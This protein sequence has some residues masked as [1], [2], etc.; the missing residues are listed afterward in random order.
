MKQAVPPLELLADAPFTFRS[1]V[2]S[3]NRKVRKAKFT[4]VNNT[5]P[6]AAVCQVRFNGKTFEVKHPLSFEL[7]VPSAYGT[8]PVK[9]TAKDAA[10]KDL[11]SVSLPFRVNPPSKRE[12]AF[13][14]DRVMLIDGKP[15][16]PLG[17]WSVKGPKSNAEKAKIIAEC[18]FNI[19]KASNP[20]QMDDFAEHGMMVLM[21]VMEKL[22]NFKDEAHF[23]RW[24]KKYRAAMKK[25]REHPSLIGYFISDEPAWRGFPCE[26]L[27][28]AY[29]YIRKID[30][31]RPIMLNEAPRGEIRAN[32]L[33]A[34]AADIYG[35]DIYPVP[36]PNP[37]SGLN[38]KNMTSVGKYT[39]VCRQV[40]YDRKP[41]WMTLQAFAWG[42]ITKKTLVYPTEHQSRFMA[43]NAA[44]HGATGLF[45]WGINTGNDNW[46]FVRQLGKTVREL[47][48]MSPVLVAETIEPAGLKASVPEVRI[49]H[50][51]LNGA[52]WY[53]A[54]NESRK[55]L[56]AA[57]SDAGEKML[58]VFFENRKIN[59]VSGHFRDSFNAYD[60]HIYSTAEELP[61]ELKIPATR[62]MTAA[63]NLP[64]DYRNA[65]WIWYP[66][67]SKVRD[68]RAWFKREITLDSKPA[69]ALFF[70]TA[71]DY[72]R[73]Y[74][75]GK[76]VMEHYK[77]VGGGWGTL[78]FRDAAP[79]LSAGKNT[80][81][82]KAADG[83]GAPCGLFYAGVITEKS[84]KVRKIYS[85]AE[86]LCSEDNQTWVKSEIVC[87]FGGAPWSSCTL[88][89]A[90]AE[91]L[92]A[93]GFPF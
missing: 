87:P 36:E 23:A 56:S 84:G 64:D 48:K 63:L 4:I 22:P 13:R 73:M 54:V 33:Y 8:Y 18:G 29:D 74:I 44:A 79:F 38:D 50:K 5:V 92:G 89:P 91:N 15:F 60:V 41:V 61:P 28:Q 40:V 78:S 20:E 93:F 21:N 35:V 81:L 59:P 16:F 1:G 9:V 10:G 49:L 68:H 11:A 37:H 69:K 7:D 19:A 46:D 14:K 53:I 32:R 57:F 82:I 3:A 45:W 6:D 72:F 24:D 62:R 80:I 66:G 71:D 52:D 26:K 51:K 83:G 58:N 77:G 42:A 88:K 70:C 86:T 90:D 55:D 27:V 12:I 85:D 25:Y 47:R 34:A 75:N 2:Y 30:P 76:P 67:K 39:D 65:N 31:Y 43:Y 17:V